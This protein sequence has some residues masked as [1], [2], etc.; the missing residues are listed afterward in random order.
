MTTINNNTYN[1]NIFDTPNISTPKVLGFG[2][3]KPLNI[4]P[5]PINKEIVSAVMDI[6]VTTITLTPV[7]I[8]K[9]S[10]SPRSKPR[11]PKKDQKKNQKK[12]ITLSEYK[13]ECEA[14]QALLRGTVED[15]IENTTILETPTPTTENI[16]SAKTL[17]NRRKKARAKAKKNEG[18]T[19]V[20]PKSQETHA[21]ISLPNGWSETLYTGPSSTSR[22]ANTTLILKNLPY[23]GTNDK[24]IKRFFQ[25]MTGQNVRFVNILL[26]KETGDCKGIAFIRFEKVLGSDLGVTLNGFWYE[27][28]TIYVEYAQDRR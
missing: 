8:E 13:A 12:L 15:S 25:K 19:V 2:D 7:C 6:L 5:R 14:K 21:K 23:R 9:S 11:R 4:D 3:W 20:K 18:F 27:N 17:R 24:D 26:N 28:R 1:N 22:H 16:T 10:R